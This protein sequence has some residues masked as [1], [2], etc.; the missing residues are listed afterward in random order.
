MTFLCKHCDIEVASRAALV[1][2]WQ[3]RREQDD[4]HYHCRKCMQLFSNPGAAD[5]H[6]K[7]VGTS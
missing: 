6:H 1:E 5:R 4:K 7:E 2:H 3:E